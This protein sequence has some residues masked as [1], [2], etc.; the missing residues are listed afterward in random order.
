MR[1]DD[2]VQDRTDHATGHEL[3]AAV[4]GDTTEPA[5]RQGHPAVR[6]SLALLDC[7]AVDGGDAR[8]NAIVISPDGDREC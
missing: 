2:S 3:R 5:R 6:S 8:A 7:R 4:D 1:Q